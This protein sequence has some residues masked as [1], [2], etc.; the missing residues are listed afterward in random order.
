VDVDGSWQTLITILI[1][2]VGFFL[3]VLVN[4]KDSIELDN[5]IRVYDELILKAILDQAKVYYA[6]I[7]KELTSAYG[8]IASFLKGAS[9]VDA[10]YEEVSIPFSLST[11]MHF[12][13]GLLKRNIEHIR[14]DYDWLKRLEGFRRWLTIFYYVFL[15]V[16]ILAG[17]VFLVTI[18]KVAH[19]DKAIPTALLCTSIVVIVLFVVFRINLDRTLSKTRQ[20][21]EI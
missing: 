4:R 10:G 1:S 17:F 2:S 13:E 20:A 9:A 8:E 18:T 12:D 3:N 5:S 11:T 7:E 6:K 15:A 21:H 19:F 16:L 14:D